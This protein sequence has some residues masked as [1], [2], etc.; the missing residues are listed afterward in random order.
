MQQPN[1]NE[2]E[3]LFQCIYCFKS[4]STLKGILCHEKIYCKKKTACNRCG[5]H[6]HYT[7]DC[8]ASTHVSNKYLI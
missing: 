6:G 5:R 7:I 8:Y 3:I 4:Y 2:N 1:I